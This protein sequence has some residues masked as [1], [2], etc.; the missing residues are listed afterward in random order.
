MHVQ[1]NVI[2]AE[3]LKAAQKHPVNYPGLM[4]RVT[5]YSAQFAELDVTVQN[6]IISR[7]EHSF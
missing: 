5:G 6:D 3:T 2:S 7:T 4:V 1:C